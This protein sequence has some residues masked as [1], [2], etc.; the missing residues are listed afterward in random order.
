MSAPSYLRFIHPNGFGSFTISRTQSVR[1]EQRHSTL[2]IIQAGKVVLVSIA[3][4]YWLIS[5]CAD[6]LWGSFII[7]EIRAVGEVLADLANN[8]ATKKK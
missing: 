5:W 7:E 6:T 4:A 1:R 8:Q 2:T 3:L